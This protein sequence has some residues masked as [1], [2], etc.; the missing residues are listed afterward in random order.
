MFFLHQ[1]FSGVGKK[2]T[3]APYAN[4]TPL[5]IPPDHLLT[6][7]VMIHEN[8]KYELESLNCFKSF[9]PDGIYQKLLES[10]V[11]DFKFVEAVVILFRAIST[12]I[13]T[14]PK[15]WKSANV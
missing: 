9:G 1:S 3:G 15:V 12:G 14:I 13:V 4:V 8:V 10:F 2:S 7:I 6:D 11:N 5:P